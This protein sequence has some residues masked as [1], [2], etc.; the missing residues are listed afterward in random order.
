M[1]RFQNASFAV[2][3]FAWLTISRAR[4]APLGDRDTLQSHASQLSYAACAWQQVPRITQELVEFTLTAAQAADQLPSAPQGA[5]SFGT[6]SQHGP[7]QQGVQQG[8][9][10]TSSTAH[11]PSFTLQHTPGHTPARRDT[12]TPPAPPPHF[13]LL[14]PDWAQ[15]VSEVTNAA[16]AGAPVVVAVVGPKHVGKSSLCRALVNRLL[17]R[18]PCVGFLDTD[19]GQPELTPPGDMG[20]SAVG[21]GRWACVMQYIGLSLIGLGWSTVC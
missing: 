4:A 6:P 21:G 3:W 10:G 1:L 18:H 17:S 9:A 19:C 7:G 5:A 13:V 12:A 2:S 14:P 16:D 15:A 8:G 20:M 11:S